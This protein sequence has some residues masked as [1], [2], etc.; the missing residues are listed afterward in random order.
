MSD[1]LMLAGNEPDIYLSLVTFNREA[2]RYLSRSINLITTTSF[3]VYS[4][5]LHAF[6]PGKFV[7]F[8][9][10]DFELYENAPV[11]SKSSGVRFDGHITK[12]KIEEILERTF[13]PDDILTGH[14]LH[15][16]APISLQAT[17]RVT[18]SKWQFVSLS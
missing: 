4:P 12:V 13:K 18:R 16:A 11:I 14:L 15:W 8:K 5:E 10:M 1:K 7:G 2:K 6:G 3:W 17:A 9:D